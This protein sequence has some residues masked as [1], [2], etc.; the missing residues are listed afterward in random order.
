MTQHQPRAGGA[1]RKSGQD[2]NRP[3]PAPDSTP[4]HPSDNKIIVERK[5]IVQRV[6]RG[7]VVRALYQPVA[8][9][10]LIVLLYGGYHQTDTI[11]WLQ[12]L[13]NTLLGGQN[14]TR[15]AKYELDIAS[16]QAE[17]R[18]LV[19]ANKAI[20]ERLS[21]L[22]D[23]DP[24][25]A[26]ARLLVIHNGMNGVTNLSMLRYDL[27]HSVPNVGHV[28]GPLTQN[29]PLTE[30]SRLLPPLLEGKCVPIRVATVASAALRARLEALNVAAFLMCP[31]I[32]DRGRL[33][34]A[35][36]INW[37]V[38]TTLPSNAALDRLMIATIDTGHAV[39]T[40]LN[41]HSP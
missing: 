26:R 7:P 40:I 23:L 20:E 3:A 19:F 17:M 41:L 1:R 9:V 24:S 15:A 34:A 39:A 18:H 29:Q 37:D 30:W 14:P 38:G 13:R 36:S 25:I 10:G 22:F 33:L 32:D 6:L 31:V 12:R 21:R 27:T 11:S 16:Q 2:R 4:G 5:G 8:T 28:S 35:I